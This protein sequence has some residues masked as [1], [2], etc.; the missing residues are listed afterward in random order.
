LIQLVV[1]VD[2]IERYLRSLPRKGKT[3]P[4]KSTI[5]VTVLRGGQ[6]AERSVSLESGAAVADACRRLGYVVTEADIGPADLRAL[7]EQADVVFPVLHG[8]FGEDGRLQA[9]LEDRGQPYVG[10]GPDA[11]R[12]AMDKDASKRQWQAAGLPTAPWVTIDPV[13]PLELSND[14]SLP[15][16]MKP[17]SEGSSIGVRMCDTAEHLNEVVAE[18][19]GRY[20]RVLVERRL[21]GPELTVGILGDTPLPVIQVKPANEFFDYDAKYIR[22]DTIHSFKLDVDEETRESVQKLAMRAFRTLGCRGFGRVDII[23]DES[24]GPQILE[25]NTIPGFTGH[26]LLPKAAAQAGIGFDQLVDELVQMA[27]RN[28]RSKRS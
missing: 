7:D 4:V 24:A 10:S 12:L 17:V 22:D 5:H 8:S 6:S 11:S 28:E 26:S 18:A 3:R 1:S 16:V 23:V 9:I 14:V 21:V 20:R 19:A 27:L 2:R 15:V 25:L 13:E